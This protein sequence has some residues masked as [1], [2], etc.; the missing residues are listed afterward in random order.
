MTMQAIAII[1]MVFGRYFF[2]YVPAGTEQFALFCLVWFAMLSIALSIRDDSHVKME[3][4]DLWL[5]PT[6]V[7]W[8]KYLA[9]ACTLLFSYVLIRYGYAVCQLT[10]PVLLNGFRVP[11]SWLYAAAPISGVC[12]ALNTLCYII[13]TIAKHKAAGKEKPQ[14]A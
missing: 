9:A 7:V 2:N 11:S 3:L 8:F 4:V 13:E 1:V 14:N 10:A 6:Q 12:V 5:K